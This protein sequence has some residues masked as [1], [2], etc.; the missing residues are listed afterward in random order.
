MSRRGRAEMLRERGTATPAVESSFL[1]RKSAV[2]PTASQGALLVE[3]DA[4]AAPGQMRKSELLA[5]LRPAL[6]AAADRELARQGRDTRGCPYLERAFTHYASLSAAR[7]ERALRGFAP[8]AA[9]VTSAVDLI[10]IV[11]SRVAD[12]VRRWAATGELPE[13]PDA[14]GF[15]DVAPAG[16]LA[17]LGGSLLGGLGRLF[18]KSSGAAPGVA[19]RTSPLPLAQASGAPLAPDVSDRMG[20]VMGRG[21]SHVRV[22]ADAESGALAG[23]LGARA[24]TV[25]D[26]L[27][28]APGEYRPGTPV[29]DAL[30]AHELAHVAQQGTA[31]G[32][33]PLEKARPAHDGALEA[34]A[35]AAAEGAVV[36]IWGRTAKGA[37]ELRRRVGPRLRTGLKLQM[38]SCGGAPAARTTTPSRVATPAP[39]AAETTAPQPAAPPRAAEQ[40]PVARDPS[41]DDAGLSPDNL[42]E[43][44]RRFGRTDTANEVLDWLTQRGIAV[45]V[46]PVADARNL[47]G[48]DQEAAGTYRCR[49]RACRVFVVAGTGTSQSVRNPSGSTTLQ[50]GIGDRP[51]DQIAE[52]IFHELL[53]VWFV[54]R[55]P[56]QGTGHTERTQPQEIFLGR[57]QIRDEWNYDGRFLDQLRRF[58]RELEA[59]RGQGGER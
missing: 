2:S 40:L 49:G 4:A 8:G 45:T 41:F 11:A 21:F 5:R 9:R 58:H 52:T 51:P 16:L 20:T 55:F 54:H 3:D 14:P 31:V 24:F 12:G 22:H 48:G 59:P 39:P 10:P 26:H 56:D 1:Q 17:G 19:S 6:C 13:L 23:R 29:G 44:L 46:V 32:E 37:R 38:S 35:D 25:G 36:S 33:A 34:D 43:A 47:P 28:F 42:T 27:A 18:F 57:R 15:S 7:L 50:R 30:L 53:H